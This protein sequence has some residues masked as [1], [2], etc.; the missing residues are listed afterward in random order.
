MN[1]TSVQLFA[2]T[3]QGPLPLSVPAG[4]RNIHDLFDT[5]PAGCYTAFATF[6]HNKFFLLTDHLDRLENSL[7]LMGW[8]YQLDRIALRRALHEVVSAY[9]LPF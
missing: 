6:D 8:D 3:P 4:A 7:I 5:L 2:V 1:M 9:P